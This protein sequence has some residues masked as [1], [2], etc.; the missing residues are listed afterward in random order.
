MKQ[1]WI[2]S[3]AVAAVVLTGLVH[4]FWTERWTTNDSAALAATRLKQIANDLGDWAGE[5]MIETPRQTDGIS[6]FLYR[7]YVHRQT[8]TTITV[9][10]YCGRAGP[11]SIH[12]PDVCYA[13]GGYDVGASVK[14]AIGSAEF[15]TAQ[16]FKTS[17]TDRSQLRIFWSWNATGEW[18]VPDSP[19][20]AFASRP[21]LYKLY[22][23]RETTD[24]G[25]SLKNEPCLEF[26]ELLLPELQRS[27]FSSS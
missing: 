4:G 11:M 13:G 24:I 12:T 15:R 23:I 17:A 6:G 3:S 19:R 25:D 26:M 21:F 8:G 16:F 5:P 2:G 10:L 27:L 22:V 14:H 9:A 7:R 18:Q 1:F 20:F